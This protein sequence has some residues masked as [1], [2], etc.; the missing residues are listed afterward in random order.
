MD[1]EKIEYV[2]LSGSLPAGL[3]LNADGTITG[4]ATAKAGEY[5]FTVQGRA[6]NWI[7]A[8]RQYTLTLDS[9]F[10]IDE[11]EAY[12][13]EDFYAVIESDIV[14]EKAYSEGVVYAVK[15]GKLPAGLTLN[16]DGEIEG[17]PTEAGEFT[18]TVGVT[19]TNQSGSGWRVSTTV[20]NFE[21]DVT[22][23]VEE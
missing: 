1:A 6:D 3:T 5:A 23:T 21:Y 7:T 22:I 9:A 13:G 15:E 8:N 19:A 2:V 4:T 20:T 16:A 11:T 12:L 10:V 18:F 17:I 14:N